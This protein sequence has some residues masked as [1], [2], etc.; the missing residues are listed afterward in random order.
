MVDPRGVW[1][2]FSGPDAAT[3]KGESGASPEGMLRTG[4]AP[5]KEVEGERG[6]PEKAQ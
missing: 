3:P 4:S 2:S 5:L 6:P 1:S